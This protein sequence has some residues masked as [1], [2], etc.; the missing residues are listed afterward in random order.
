[1]NREEFVLEIKKKIIKN[2]P[3]DLTNDPQRIGVRL[4]DVEENI[5]LINFNGIATNV[6]IN[7]KVL[8]TA[9]YYF[10]E[11]TIDHLSDVLLACEEYDIEQEKTL[12]RCSN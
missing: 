3:M 8:D 10:D 4:G 2:G 9:E 12:K 11:L 1:M 6:S 5:T 7:G